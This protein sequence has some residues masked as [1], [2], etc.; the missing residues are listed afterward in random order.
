MVVGDADTAGGINAL[1]VTTRVTV[2]VCVPEDV[3]MPMVPVQVAAAVNEDG[4]TETVKVVFDGEAVKLPVGVRVSQ[5]LL[6][7]VCSDA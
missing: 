1:V 6:V 7:Q 5:V 3:T 4:S 2:S